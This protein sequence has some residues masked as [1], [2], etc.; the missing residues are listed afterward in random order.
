[1][2]F[3]HSEEEKNEAPWG[4]LADL[5]SGLM[6]IFLFVA[7]AFLSHVQKGTKKYS[8]LKA[9][10]YDDLANNFRNDLGRWNAEIDPETLVVR[11][12][13]PDIYFDI[14]KAEMKSG[15]KNILADFFPRYVSVLRSKELYQQYID[16]LRIE[17]HTS[18]EWH[19]KASSE[20]AYSQNLKLSQERARNVLQYCREILG[21]GRIPT[22]AL[23]ETTLTWATKILVATGLSSSRAILN[24]AGLEDVEKSRRVEFRVSL[25]ADTFIEDMGK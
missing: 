12:K 23:G 2:L 8:S 14:G 16:E 11:F 19:Q 15:F 4:S 20:L 9:Q 6:M 13:E 5:M 7:V 10:I 3:D 24:Q 25:K 18:S 22:S 21:A 17:G 1:M